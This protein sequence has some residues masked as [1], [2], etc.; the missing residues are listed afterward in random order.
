[1]YKKNFEVVER[2]P[3]IVFRVAIFLQ[4]DY[5]KN[6]SKDVQKSETEN[7]STMS[8]TNVG[9]MVYHSNYLKLFTVMQ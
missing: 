4:F 7:M 2:E 3:N 5:V 8:L 9:H 6:R 1:M